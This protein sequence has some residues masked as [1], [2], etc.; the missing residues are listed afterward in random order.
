MVLLGVAWTPRLF[1]STSST[2][3]VSALFQKQMFLNCV[4]F[5]RG[6]SVSL[7][8]EYQPELAHAIPYSERSSFSPF[9]KYVLANKQLKKSNFSAH[10]N[11]HE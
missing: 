1:F 11:E 2:T 8:M 7:A 6:D 9:R 3:L 10:E 5:L 4:Y